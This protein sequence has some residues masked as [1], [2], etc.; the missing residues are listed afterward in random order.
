MAKGGSHLDW[1]IKNHNAFNL[2]SITAVIHGFSNDKIWF[3]HYK[4]LLNTSITLWLSKYLVQLIMVASNKELDIPFSIVLGANLAQERGRNLERSW[5]R[6]K[7]LKKTPGPL[8]K[9]SLIWSEWV[10]DGNLDAKVLINHLAQISCK[11][12]IQVKSHKEVQSGRHK[13]QVTI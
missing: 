13:C 3:E 9:M 5:R 10:V 1:N 11:T 6:K 12:Y 8:L 2:H 4:S 7:A